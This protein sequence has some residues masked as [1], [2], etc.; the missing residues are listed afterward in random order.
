MHSVCCCSLPVCT[1]SSLKG[2]L[3]DLFL[4]RHESYPGRIWLKNN[5]TCK[6]PCVLHAY[7]CKIQKNWCTVTVAPTIEHHGGHSRTPVNQRWDQVSSKSI[8]L[9]R[10]RSWKCPTDGRRTDAGRHVITIDH[11]STKQGL[12]L[13][14]AYVLKQE[15]LC[16]VF[17]ESR[18]FISPNLIKIRL[19]I[20]VSLQFKI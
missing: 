18:I 16:K 14:S 8:K 19:D 2:I 13:K 4:P 17:S 12:M 1:R 6:G 3:Y 5:N 9:F 10:R 15:A 11:W 7:Q 20:S